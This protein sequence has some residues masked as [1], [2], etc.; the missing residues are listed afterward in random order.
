MENYVNNLA[1]HHLLSHG[2]KEIDVED[3]L[4]IIFLP[5]IMI[6][7]K[8]SIDHLSLGVTSKKQRADCIVKGKRNH[9]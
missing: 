7:K 3:P 2:I 1:V 4:S 5:Q 8:Q 6:S 9:E